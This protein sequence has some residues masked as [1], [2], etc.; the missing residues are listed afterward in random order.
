MAMLNNHRIPSLII[1]DPLLV[2]SFA[3]DPI[4]SL[5]SW[6][7]AGVMALKFMPFG[8]LFVS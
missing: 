7:Q 3:E 4:R 5:I 2:D 1:S 6:S 8:G